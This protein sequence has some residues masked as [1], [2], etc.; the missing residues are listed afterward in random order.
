MLIKEFVCQ[1]KH[2]KTFKKQKTSKTFEVNIKNKTLKKTCLK[3]IK[4]QSQHCFMCFN[5]CYY[6]VFNVDFEFVM[7][8]SIVFML[9]SICYVLTSNCFNVFYVDFEFFCVGSLYAHQGVCLS[10]C[11]VSEIVGCWV[12]YRL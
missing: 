7:L 10:A 11:F 1:L 12:L 5:I 8:T 2:K 9:T 3:N 6:H 4:K